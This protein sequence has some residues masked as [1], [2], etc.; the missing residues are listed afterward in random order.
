MPA[1][2]VMLERPEAPETPE[3]LEVPETLVLPETL[4]VRAVPVRPAATRT[5]VLPR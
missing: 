2:P 3:R 4:A 5:R 1:Q